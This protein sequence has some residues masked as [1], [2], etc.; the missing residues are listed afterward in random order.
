[1]R[2]PVQPVVQRMPKI[3]AVKPP[4]METPP[5]PP[6]PVVMP[7]PVDSQ[8][9]PDSIPV[10]PSAGPAS[11][12]TTVTDPPPAVRTP[13]KVAV[14]TAQPAAAPAGGEK[15]LARV[16]PDYRKTTGKIYPTKA[17]RRHEE[18]LVIV[19][20]LVDEQGRPKSVQLKQSSGHRLLDDAAVNAVRLGD[21]KTNRIDGQ[22]VATEV[23]Q[24][25]NFKLT[26][27]RP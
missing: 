1:M 2:Q 12:V 15:I 22:A 14:V 8:L 27:P 17:I 13:D 26:D 6:K 18:G 10:Q 16:R 20:V 9:S 5:A 24:P 11:A 19:T 25:V 4:E 21:F 23:G 3:V 7:V